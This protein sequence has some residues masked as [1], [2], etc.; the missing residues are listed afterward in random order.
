MRWQD[1]PF[2]HLLVSLP[3]ARTARTE[4]DVVYAVEIVYYDTKRE[5]DQPAREGRVSRT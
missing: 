1:L 2:A 3:E 4:Y 5:S